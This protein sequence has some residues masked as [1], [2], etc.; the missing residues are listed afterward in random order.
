NSSAMVF[1][2][3]A[4]ADFAYDTSVTYHEFTH[5]MVYTVA[6]FSG[7]AFYGNHH[8]AHDEAGA[9]N[10][11]IAD[12]FASAHLQDPVSGQYVG[13]RLAGGTQDVALRDLTHNDKCPQV[14]WGE[15]HQDSQHFSEA[16]WQTRDNFKLNPDGGSDGRTFDS[17]VY[18]A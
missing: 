17:A 7:I 15:V 14:L 12:Y 10:E 3:G 18:A 9:M 16:L 6:D 8:G 2:Q 1:F 5:G 11:G 13:P 4:K